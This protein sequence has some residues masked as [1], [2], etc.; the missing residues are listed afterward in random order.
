MK[1]GSIDGPVT[2]KGF[3]NWVELNSF[4]YGLSRGVTSGAGGSTR[5]SSH[6]SVS[7]I[8]VTKHYDTA[9]PNLYQNSVAGNLD[10][11][12]HIK[13]TQTTK[14]GTD[15]YLSYELTKCGVSSYSLSSGGDKPME[16][17][18]LNFLKVMVTPTPI[19]DAGQVKKG[20]V[21]TYD[22]QEMVAS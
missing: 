13:M 12:V 19:D 1:F 16:S 21:V 2:T 7:E 11:T 22:L 5:E 3:K 8:V 14:M 9:S 17:M 10:A 15:T 4:Q 6:P 18:S 20:D